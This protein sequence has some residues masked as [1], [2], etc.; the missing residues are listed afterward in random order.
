MDTMSQRTAH[1][2]LAAPHKRGGSA[3]GNYR[4]W[5]SAESRSKAKDLAEPLELVWRRHRAEALAHL[6]LIEEALAA[7]ATLQLDEELHTRAKRAAHMLAGSVGTFGFARASEVARELE[8]E[9][10]KAVPARLPTM[11]WLTAILRREL[12]GGASSSEADDDAHPDDEHVRVLVVDSDRALCER[13][14]SACERRAMLCD[15]AANPQEAWAL[16]AKHRPTIVLLDLALPE[17]E[18]ADGYTLLSELS[19]SEPP[20][21][22]LVLTD[23]G[24]FTDRVEAAR[25][26]SRAFLPKSLLPAEV[27][28]AVEEFLARDRLAATRVLAV[29]D[30]PTVLDVMGAMLRPHQVELHTL[31]DPGHF[32]E[33]LE[34]VEPELLILD[35]DMPGVNGPELCRTVRNDPRWSRLAVIFATARTDA[36]TV[37]A[38]FNAGADDYVAKPIVGPELVSRVSNR[39]ER[40]RMYRAQAETDG[41]TGLSNRVTSEKGLKQ[42]AA[43][44]DRFSEPLS[45]A[46]LDVDRFKSINDTHGHAVGDSVLRSVGEYLRREFRGND[47]VGRWGGEEFVIGL[48][49]MARDD[50]V[51]RLTDMLER[52]GSEAFQGATGTL[53][54]TFSAGVAEHGL[55]GS[56]V[57]ALCEAADEALYRAKA[58]GRAR[59]MAAGEASLSAPA[60]EAG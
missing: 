22:V 51:R 2:K 57:D 54:V 24:S 18:L 44:S 3:D 55:D 41:L 39:L 6:S 31:L 45:L 59:V 28:G 13:I 14:A 1:R 15:R 33:A 43:L 36:E 49:G 21:P 23:G 35:V 32:W 56:G 4:A 40:V 25:R 34:E 38:V 7:L 8:Q 16:L 10:E 47:V 29:D 12:D 19:C 46:M 5:R 52:F 37:E 50:A 30:D 9:L 60:T 58:A 20:I 48:Y 26:G 53:H 42:L 27:L 17:A 11:S